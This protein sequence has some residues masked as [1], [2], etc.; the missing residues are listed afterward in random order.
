MRNDMS[1]QKDPLG[2][3]QIARI[4]IGH[5]GISNRVARVLIVLF[6]L[7]LAVVPVAQYIHEVR[8]YVSGRRDSAWPGRPQTAQAAGEGSFFARVLSA[9]RRLLEEINRFEE[10]LE[11]NSVGGGMLLPRV[12][13]LLTRGF[14]VG[15]E[16]A[17]CGR[18]G[19]LFYRS[20]I[21]YLTGPGFLDS[22]QLTRRRAS[23]G[24]S[25]PDPR[26]A[27]LDFKRQLEGRGIVLIVV[28]T[29]V[30]P[31]V[32]PEQFAGRYEGGYVPLK[33]PSYD[34]LKKP[35]EAGG[36]PVFD[37]AAQVLAA[38]NR[39]RGPQ[40]LRTDT[41]W[42]PEAIH[43]V[44]ERLKT[45]IEHH[46]D[47]PSVRSPGYERAAV[48]VANLGDIAVML[49]LPQ[50]QT[51]YPRERVHLEEVRTA[52]GGLWRADRAADILVLGDS[53]SN[54][55]SL[56][57]M[58]WGESAGFVEQLAFLLQRPLDRIVCN[59][60]GAY[61]TR[62]VLS[63]ELA[64]GRDRLAGKRLVIWQFAVRE[65]GDGDWKPIGMDLGAP[66]PRRFVVPVPG[67]ERVVSGTVQTAASAPRPG[68]VPYRDH[69]VAVHLA[70]LE[71]ANGPIE[72]GEAVVYMWS[73]RDHVWTPAARYRSGQRVTVRLQ[74][75]TRVADR[76]DGINRSELDDEDLLFEEPCWGEEVEQ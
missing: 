35:L 41:H 22:G 61:A 49:R 7:T 29:P 26:V 47:L 27:I 58:G 42:R 57:A 65:L 1:E 36:V 38:A 19:W 63:R 39:D 8:E 71:D 55:Y 44:A 12:Q 70:D 74:A 10:A 76:Y 16:Q 3:T 43:L 64:L 46:V 72:G 52:S 15:N 60:D 31:V 6:L 56:G 2:R 17:Y 37:E 33:N 21:D 32:H 51:L 50:N 59:D 11:D 66:R 75:W 14:G 62:Q 45:F 13:Y 53:F 25:Q 4:E 30:K 20:G 48:D 23:G 69:I 67:G 68:S 40:Y 9:N 5:T 54:I 28:P 24:E 73:M 18:E 34:A